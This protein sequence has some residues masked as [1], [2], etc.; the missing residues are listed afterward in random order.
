MTSAVTDVVARPLE[1][2]EAPAIVTVGAAMF[3]DALTAQALTPTR[4]E[5]TPPADDTGPAL[6]R[7]AGDPRT[8]AANAE[9]ARRLTAA[10]PQWVDIATARDVLG[11]EP[12]EF[13]HAGPPVDWAN[14]CGP[15]QG[16]LAGAIV[17]E[18]LA[19]T[20]E[21][22]ER[23]AAS[24][25][26]K[27]APCHGRGA[28]GPMAGVVSASMPVSVLEDATSGRRSY[29]TLNEGLGVVLRYGAYSPEVIEKRCA[30]TAR[31]T[32]SG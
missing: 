6:A 28:V 10:K 3:A 7:I 22:A 20:V 24:G 19:A 32:W 4:V 17:Y 5:W 13:L 12:D 31:S 18:G 21:E 14:A 29:C 9:A 11:L 30:G 25:G 8:A 1:L 2:D 15:M 26:I 23:L 27:L 16:A